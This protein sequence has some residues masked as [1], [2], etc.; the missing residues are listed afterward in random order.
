MGDF[1][2][3]FQGY[4]NLTYFRLNGFKEQLHTSNIGIPAILSD[5]HIRYFGNEISINSKK[6]NQLLVFVV[7]QP[8]T[9]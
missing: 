3:N 5:Q 6:K 8:Q 1:G 7:M 2:K 4:E 9:N